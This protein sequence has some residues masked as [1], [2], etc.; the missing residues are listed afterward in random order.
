MKTV[1]LPLRVPQI[2]EILPHR[3]PFLLVDAVTDF[4]DGQYIAGYKN[5]SANE[6]FFVGH[7]P[8]RP[9]MPGVLQLEALA[10]IGA[11]FANLT[12]GG[13]RAGQLIVFSGADEVRFRKLVQPGDVLTLRMEIDRRRGIHWRMHGTAKVGEVVTAEAMIMAT[14]IPDA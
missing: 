5:V 11:I 13:A 7:F 12:T 10:Q 3:Y 8:N 2:Q 1:E 9:I 6:P 4:I 14:E